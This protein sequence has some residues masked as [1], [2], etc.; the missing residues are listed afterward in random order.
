ML[1]WLALGIVFVTVY[2]LYLGD[3]VL[4]IIGD[5]KT[6]PIETSFTLA[7]IMAIVVLVNIA[8]NK[9]IARHSQNN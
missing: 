3:T 8:I 7:V 9:R 4:G 6:K 5:F 2:T 1:I